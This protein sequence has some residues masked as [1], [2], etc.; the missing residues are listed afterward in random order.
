LDSSIARTY[1]GTGLGLAL[2]SRFCDMLGGTVVVH[3][4]LGQGSRFTVRLPATIGNAADVDR[5]SPLFR[6]SA[7]PSQG[8]DAYRH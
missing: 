3:S 6:R 4:A 2:V 1:G 7:V 8:P 5:S